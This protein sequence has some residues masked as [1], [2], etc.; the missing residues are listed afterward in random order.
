MSLANI[1]GWARPVRIA[2]NSSRATSTA[3]AIFWSASLRVSLINASLLR[4]GVPLG[5]GAGVQPALTSVPI[6]SPCTTRGMSPSACMPKTIIGRWFSMHSANA[7]ASATFRPCCSASTKVS[8]SYFI[9]SGCVRGS[10][11]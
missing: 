7:V 8:S 9:A 6:F 2:A 10:A 11:V 4:R 1:D 5:V 3:L